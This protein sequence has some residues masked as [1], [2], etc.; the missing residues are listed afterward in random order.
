MEWNIWNISPH[1]AVNTDSQV[2]NPLQG[3]LLVCC[4]V[5]G[6]RSVWTF[7]IGETEQPRHNMRPRTQ[8]YSP[9]SFKCRCLHFGLSRHDT[10][11]KQKRPCRSTV[12]DHHQ[13]EVV[14]FN[15]SWWCWSITQ[16][17]D[18]LP[19]DLAHTLITPWPLWLQWATSWVTWGSVWV[20]DTEAFWMKAGQILRH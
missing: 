5:Q 17:W 8:L 10:W 7:Y 3:C 12:I 4:A 16:T 6:G 9:L 13:T 2:F 1:T 11:F 19:G 20:K 15:T 14:V 18:A